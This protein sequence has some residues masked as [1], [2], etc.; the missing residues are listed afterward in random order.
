MDAA[1]RISDEFLGSGELIVYTDSRHSN[2]NRKYRASRGGAFEKEPVIVL[3]DENS[4]SASEIVSGALQDHDRGLI[5]GRRT[6]GKGL[7]QQQFSL[8]DGSV[9]ADDHLA[10]LHALRVALSRRR[11]R[12]GRKR[13]RLLPLQGRVRASKTGTCSKS[14]ARARSARPRLARTCPTRSSTAPTAGRL[15]YGGGGILPDYI[16]PT[17]SISAALRTTIRKA[18]DTEFARIYLD[19]NP[20]LRDEWTERG[21][22]AFVRTYKPSNDIFDGFVELAEQRGVEDRQ[23]ASQGRR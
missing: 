7:V 1:V 14:L 3:V 9:S 2:F 13:R 6:F 20:S 11:L 17:D 12:K 18:L 8:T 4:A 19:Q 5:V 10:L 16:V 22:Q 21:V 23:R 15:V